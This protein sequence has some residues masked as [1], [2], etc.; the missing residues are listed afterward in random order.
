MTSTAEVDASILT[1]LEELKAMEDSEMYFPTQT[2]E[3]TTSVGVSM[4]IRG[5]ENALAW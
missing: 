5:L 3:T 1:L 2:P 4:A